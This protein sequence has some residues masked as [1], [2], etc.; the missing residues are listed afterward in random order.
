MFVDELCSSS[1]KTFLIYLFAFL[2]V[3]VLAFSFF[4][5][6]V[7]KST[8]TYPWLSVSKLRFQVVVH[9]Y[10]ERF[11]HFC[12]PKRLF[13]GRVLLK[14]LGLPESGNKCCT[15]ADAGWSLAAQ[16]QLPYT[17]VTAVQHRKITFSRH[18]YERLSLWEIKIKKENWSCSPSGTDVLSSLALPHVGLLKLPP[19]AFKRLSAE[20]V[21]SPLFSRFLFCKVSAFWKTKLCMCAKY[22]GRESTITDSGGGGGG[23]EGGGR[24]TETWVGGSE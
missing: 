20:P 17:C 12:S 18:Y 13:E 24:V 16:A 2:I 4:L 6:P 3:I 23:L 19:K 22:G 8:R 10:H 7:L 11:I 5:H 1:S 9:S 14:L 15:V 21:K